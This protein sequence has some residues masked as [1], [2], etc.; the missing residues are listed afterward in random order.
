MVFNATF[1]NIS[2]ISWRP[3]LLMEETRKKIINPVQVTDKLYHI[4][5]YRLSEIRSHN[6]SGIGTD[7]TGSCKSNYYVINTT[8]AP[9]QHV[10][11]SRLIIN[12]EKRT[13][14][15]DN[16]FIEIV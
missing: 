1:S 14:R 11:I 3:V 4:M 7:Y 13:P 16:T 9:P 6:I 10:D 2:A 15:V 8:T 12:R 5:L